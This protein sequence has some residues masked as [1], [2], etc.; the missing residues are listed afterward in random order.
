[1]P[2]TSV[3]PWTALRMWLKKPPTLYCSRK[4][5]CAGTWG[6]W[7]TGHFANTLKYV[8]MATSANFGNMFSMQ[9]LPSSFHFC[10]SCPNKSCLRIWWTDF[11]KWNIAS[12]NVD[13]EMTMQP[14]RWDI[15]FIRKFMLTFGILSSVFDYLTFGALLLVLHATKPNSDRVVYGISHFSFIGGTG[16]SKPKNYSPQP[17][18]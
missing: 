8:F 16:N 6:T 3:F 11:R 4:I 15:K 18:R 1:M 7:G 12:D 13:T 17:S 5:C 9:A 2:P 10:R 14:R